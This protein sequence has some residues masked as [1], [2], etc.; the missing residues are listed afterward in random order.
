M[1]IP[2][3]LL[4]GKHLSTLVDLLHGGSSREPKLTEVHC[5]VPQFLIFKQQ[6][7]QLLVFLGAPYQAVEQSYLDVLHR[8]FTET[9]ARCSHALLCPSSPSCRSPSAGFPNVSAPRLF[10]PPV[11]GSHV[12]HGFGLRYLSPPLLCVAE[13]ALS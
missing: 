13:T 5:S 8:N 9:E 6:Y 7:Q 4:G 12:A 11:C 3:A 1:H 10:L 2:L